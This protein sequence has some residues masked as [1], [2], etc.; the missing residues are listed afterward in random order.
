MINVSWEDAQAYV[1]WLSEK[2]GK[3]Y[4]LPTEVE[5]EYAARGTSTGRYWW[6]STED[7]NCII[8]TDYASCV[9]CAANN[10][11]TGPILSGSFPANK[12]GLF[13][14]AGNVWEWVKECYRA[15]LDSVSNILESEEQTCSKRTARGGSWRGSPLSL[16][17]TSRTGYRQEV[18]NNIIG[19][20]VV[21]SQ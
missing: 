15:N 21:Q 11:I 13:D 18:R 8:P 7:P 5:W 14:T 16:R 2:T 20:R 19:F 1:D 4:R 12:F 3:S 6:C 9:N 17:V 10:D